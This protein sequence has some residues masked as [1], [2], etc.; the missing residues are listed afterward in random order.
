[1]YIFQLFSFHAIIIMM[2]LSTFTSLDNLHSKIFMMSI[3]I[4]TFS[5][6]QRNSVK[7]LCMNQ[8]L[9]VASLLSDA[10]EP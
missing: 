6:F 3:I 5:V 10:C 9:N 2:V 7:Y 4:P 8:S 1:M